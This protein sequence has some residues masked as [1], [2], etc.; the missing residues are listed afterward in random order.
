[1]EC[2]A[3]IENREETGSIEETK[4]DGVVRQ[5]DSVFSE[6]LISASI[7]F[8][9][10][11]AGGGER[12]LP[13]PQIWDLDNPNKQKWKFILDRMEFASP[14][15]GEQIFTLDRIILVE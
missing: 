10:Q 5:V 11:H 13:L 6:R 2:R 8:I 3:I 12:V 15:P 9:G 7:I 1:M 14:P 4:S